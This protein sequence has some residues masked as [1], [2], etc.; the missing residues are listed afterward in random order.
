MPVILT[1]DTVLLTLKDDKLHVALF[2]RDRQPFQDCWALPGGYIHEQEDSDTHAAALRVLKS[3]TNIEP[4]YLEEFGTV[5]GPIRDPRGWSLTVVY[6]AL[7]PASALSEAVTLFPVNSLETIAFDHGAI[8]ERVVERVRSKASYS[9]LPVF[10]CA[11]PFTIP[12]LHA[13][14]EAVL[15]ETQDMSS[16]RRKLDD[17]QLLEALPGQLRTTGRN[18]RAQLYKLSEPFKHRLS[19]RERT[20]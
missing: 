15:E 14:Y 11:E 18:R 19:L 13:T 1:V 3:K 5:S 10:L 6:Y 12:E 16:F 8:V 7:V 4:P 20:F 17:M 2:K 9:S